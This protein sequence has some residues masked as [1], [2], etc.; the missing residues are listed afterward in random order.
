MFLLDL[1]DFMKHLKMSK[2]GSLTFNPYKRNSKLTYVAYAMIIDA[3]N[4]MHAMVAY[5]FK[6][7]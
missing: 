2:S 3:N 5:E 6:E 7:R 4:N 1:Q